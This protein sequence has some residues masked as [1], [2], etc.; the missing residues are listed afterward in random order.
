MR[1]TRFVRFDFFGT[2]MVISG[3]YNLETTIKVLKKSNLT[4]RVIFIS[5]VILFFV[6][7]TR[8]PSLVIFSVGYYFLAVGY[9]LLI[10]LASDI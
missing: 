4:K 7:E 6:G 5:Q 2:L 10:K 8:L 9:Y 1:C 3:F